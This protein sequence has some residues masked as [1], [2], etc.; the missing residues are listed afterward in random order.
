MWTWPRPRERPYATFR[1][2]TGA[3]A[4]HWASGDAPLMAVT[5]KTARAHVA[6]R[7]L[8]SPLGQ[9]LNLNGHPAAPS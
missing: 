1:D 2:A 8:R 4:P 5:P 3:L 6:V 9:V 7:F